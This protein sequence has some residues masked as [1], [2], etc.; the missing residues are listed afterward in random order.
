MLSEKKLQ[1][2]KNKYYN[3]LQSIGLAHKW[4]EAIDIKYSQNG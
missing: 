4:K 3:K 1:E 2:L